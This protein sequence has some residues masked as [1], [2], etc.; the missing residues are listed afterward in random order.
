MACY[1]MPGRWE[2]RRVGV[3][4]LGRGAFDMTLRCFPAA[5]GRFQS[6]H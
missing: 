3:A 2:G 5:M 6:G 4:G 1:T